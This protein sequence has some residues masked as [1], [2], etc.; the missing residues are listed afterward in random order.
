MTSI[1]DI[2]YDNYVIDDYD[3]ENVDIDKK[4]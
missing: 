1:E 2:P 4:Y 3:E